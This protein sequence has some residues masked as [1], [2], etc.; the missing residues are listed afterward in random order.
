M[1]IRKNILSF[2]L[3]CIS[4]Y[5][6]N[7]AISIST[8]IP[9]TSINI[10][11]EQTEATLYVNPYFIVTPKG[12]TKHI[13]NGS[14]RVATHLGTLPLSDCIDTTASGRERLQNARSY[15]QSLFNEPASIYINENETFVDIDGDDYDE[16]QWQCIDDDELE[17]DIQV[18]CDSDILLSTIQH[19]DTTV[20]DRF[21]IYFNHSDHLGS[22][23]F[24]TD[25][26]GEAKQFLHYMPYGELFANQQ[27]SSYNERFKFVARTS[28]QHFGLR[29]VAQA[30][31]VPQIVCTPLARNSPV[32]KETT[33][34]T[35]IISEQDTIPM[36][37]ITGLPLTPSPT[38]IH[39]SLH[40]HIAKTIR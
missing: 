23:T 25:Y 10:F 38:N 7:A 27:I 22:A 40:T 13:F 39:L 24:I 9:Q 17:L 30:I 6:T 3:C 35:M 16:L 1:Q 36:N 29:R 11:G 12:Y 32:K 4:C 14:Q 20:T 37:Y 34:P 21:P 31:L 18:W 28:Q 5:S 2:L 8:K 19:G 26:Y 33:N 15:T